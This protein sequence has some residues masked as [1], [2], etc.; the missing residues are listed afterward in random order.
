[1]L[2]YTAQSGLS[3]MSEPNRHAVERRLCKKSEAFVFKPHLSGKLDVWK[4]NLSL[5]FEKR[6]DV[7][8][9]ASCDFYVY[10]YRYTPARQVGSG[11][12]GSNNCAN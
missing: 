4:K 11:L 7:H 6:H 12:I 2:G 9:L 8:D 5:V 10:G 1:M 3:E